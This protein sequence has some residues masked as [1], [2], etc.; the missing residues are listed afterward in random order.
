MWL[1]EPKKPMAQTRMITLWKRSGFQTARQRSK[2]G[3][4]MVACLPPI[5][6]RNF[7]PDS[8]AAKKFLHP[9]ENPTK[10]FKGNIVKI[11]VAYFR[12][13]LLRSMAKE[14]IIDQGG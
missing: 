1:T 9:D 2:F 6:A 12:S 14:R 3:S 10:S 4:V 11:F 5:K 8:H 7:A 13:G